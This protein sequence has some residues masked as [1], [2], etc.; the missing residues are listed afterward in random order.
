MCISLSMIFPAQIARAVAT[1]LAGHE[2]V[3]G[4]GESIGSGVGVCGWQQWRG[5]W[6][7]GICE[8]AWATGV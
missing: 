8:Q 4:V 1:A 2:G 5:R 6:Q 3:C 7:A